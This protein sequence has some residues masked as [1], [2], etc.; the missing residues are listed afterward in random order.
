MFRLDRFLTLYLFR[1]FFKDSRPNQVSIPILM[2]H[3]ISDDTEKGSPGYY[4]VTT[5]PARFRE[6]MEW[7]HAHGYSVTDLAQAIQSLHNNPPLE[8]PVTVLT[9]DDGFRDFLSNAWPVLKEFGYPATVFLPTD[10]IGETR[11]R[12]K[13]RECLTWQ[14]VRELQ[15]QGVSFGSHSL[16][17]PTL[18]ALPWGQIRRELI[19]SRNNIEDA[20][21]ATVSLFSYPYAFP[22]QDRH[23]VSAFRKELLD[24]GY[25]VAVTTRIGHAQRRSDQLC[26]PRQPI[27][28][29]DDQELF[30]AK[31]AGAYNWMAAPQKAL[32]HVKSGILQRSTRQFVSLL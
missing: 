7:L 8:N 2:Y 14:E 3:S 27:N 15:T 19:E 24:G 21:Q 25:Q 5:S 6:H 9:F 32:R 29:G 11:K 17:H 12:Y 23:F 30:E 20:L 4:S 16:S 26:L 22:Q 10:Y 28:D 31:L 18:Y 1:P 13:N